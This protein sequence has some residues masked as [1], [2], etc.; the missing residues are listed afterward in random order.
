M[1]ANDHLQTEL[2]RL[3]ALARR[4]AS[5]GQM[6]L[7]KLIEG[8]LYASTRRAGWEY[9][10]GITAA[11]MEAELAAA[12]DFLREQRLSR[13]LLPVL[14]AGRRALVEQREGDLLFGE[15]PDAYV[16][17]VCGHMALGAAPQRC[18]DCGART[19]AF[20]RFVAISGWDNTDPVNPAEILQLLAQAADDLSNLVEGLDEE[21]AAGAPR[22]S[23]WS[24]RDHVA[25]LSYVQDLLDARVDVMLEYENPV[26]AATP[27]SELPTSG[28][29]GT[30]TFGDVLGVFLEKR[31]R[32]L[33]RLKGLPLR[34][35]WRTGRHPEFGQITV[36]R[37]AAYVADHEQTHLQEIESLLQRRS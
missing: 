33:D 6:N 10:P 37:Q 28:G 25:H 18:P 7:N 14:E 32:S 21:R 19:A 5:E 12:V 15:A 30:P 27:A 2:G 3:A 1:A 4:F 20:R 17:R 23:D 24:I 8:A 13:D 22:G 29:P 9:R 16:C 26:L 31:R 11:A 36:L 34:D 35:L